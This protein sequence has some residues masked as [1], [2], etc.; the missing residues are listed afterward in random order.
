MARKTRNRQFNAT[1][2][3]LIGAGITEYWYFR[4]LN[5]KGVKCIK[6]RPRL[7]GKEDAVS[8]SKR[9]KE[10]LQDGGVPIVVFDADV[11]VWNET[12]R[13]KYEELHREYDSSK[14]V[15]LYDSMPSI[16]YWFLLHYVGTNQHYGT[17]EKVIKDLR[18]YISSFSKSESF[19][20]NVKWVD[21]MLADGKMQKAISRAKQFG[22]KG[23]SWTELWRLFEK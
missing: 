17:S 14:S 18:K 3:V 7:C 4:H 1:I 12:E 23:E 20:Q 16:E 22:K 6:T 2:P 9:I 5:S 21:V 15:E 10:V 8:L 19:L 13:K 11:T